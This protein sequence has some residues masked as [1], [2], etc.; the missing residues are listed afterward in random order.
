M[1]DGCVTLHNSHWCPENSPI[2][3]AASVHWKSALTLVHWDINSWGIAGFWRQQR[4]A[5]KI[6]QAQS[7]TAGSVCD[8][9]SSISSTSVNKITHSLFLERRDQNLVKRTRDK[10]EKTQ[11]WLIFY[12]KTHYF[13]NRFLATSSVR[14]D[15]LEQVTYIPEALHW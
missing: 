2:L 1:A 3:P 13:P 4:H 14:M 11:F 8:F 9:D 6:R 12:E 15:V 5:D 10:Q 7:S